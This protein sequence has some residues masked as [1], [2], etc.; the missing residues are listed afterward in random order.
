MG[1][2][3][4]AAPYG[5]SSTSSAPRV[6]TIRQR[7]PEQMI[8][9]RGCEDRIALAT[10]ASIEFRLSKQCTD[11]WLAASRKKRQSVKR[12]R[13]RALLD[14]LGT[15]LTEPAGQLHAWIAV[16]ANKA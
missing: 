9:R 1:F 5:S 10:I 12:T 3:A 14:E 6:L 13:Q 8:L 4:D 16:G 7:L 2:G 11:F 15:A